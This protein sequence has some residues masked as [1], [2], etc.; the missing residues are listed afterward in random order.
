VWNLG[1]CLLYANAYHELGAQE[2]AEGN[3]IVPPR[4]NGSSASEIAAPG[5]KHNSRGEP[6][7]VL[8]FLKNSLKVFMRLPGGEGSTVVLLPGWP[9]TAEALQRVFPSL[10]ERHRVVADR[11]AR[12]G[13]F[14]AV[15][16][17]LWTPGPSAEFSRASLR[18]AIG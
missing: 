3:K 1:R 9:E 11:S 16:G 13:R 2:S 17:R 12:A 6:Y 8:A 18:P 15:H 4:A 7:E 14:R 10:A 5:M